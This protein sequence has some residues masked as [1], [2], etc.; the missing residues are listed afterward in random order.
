MQCREPHDL[1]LQVAQCDGERMR[2]MRAGDR[3][4]PAHALG[5]A[6]GEREADHRAVRCA[7][8]RVRA[9][10]AELGE[11]RCDRVGLILA[12]DGAASG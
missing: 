10:D 12:A 4:E 8:E 5:M 1:A 7:D 11:Q 6:R 2:A 3:D 9:A